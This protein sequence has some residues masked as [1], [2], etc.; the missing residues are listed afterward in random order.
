MQKIPAIEIDI[1]ARLES[2]RYW[3]AFSMEELAHHKAAGNIEDIEYWTEAAWEQQCIIVELE[4]MQDE[5]DKSKPEASK[6]TNRKEYLMA[7]INYIDSR[8]LCKFT[9]TANGNFA[10]YNDIV[11][12]FPSWDAMLNFLKIATDKG[13]LAVR[14]HQVGSMFFDVIQVNHAGRAIVGDA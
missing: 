9:T 13:W 1:E 7:V 14:R 5:S 8:E 12:I 11:S 3:Y 2:A 10:G 4:S 6:P